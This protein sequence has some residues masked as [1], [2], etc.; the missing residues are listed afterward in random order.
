MD[1]SSITHSDLIGMR[2]LFQYTRKCLA[3]IYIIIIT[4]LVCGA[5]LIHD[6]CN[7]AFHFFLTSVS[8]H[9]YTIFFSVVFRILLLHLLF[10]RYVSHGR[11]VLCMGYR[12]QVTSS[13]ELDYMLGVLPVI[14]PAGR[15]ILHWNG[16]IIDP[17]SIKISL[18]IATL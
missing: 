5:Q 18:W 10:G 7:G 8:F 16:M 3:Y 12:N 11:V 9:M 4:H 13:Q 14:Q 1:P 6:G 17:P 15:I 2:I